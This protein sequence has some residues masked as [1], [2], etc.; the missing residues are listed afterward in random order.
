MTLLIQNGTLVT[1]TKT[2]QSDILI[3]NGKIIQISEKINPPTSKTE[4]IDATNKLILPG[5]I[6]GHTH[7]AMPFGGTI[8][9]DDYYTGTLAAACGGTTTVFDFALQDSGETL[10]ETLKRRDE[11]AKTDVCV[12]YSFH[13]AIKDLSTDEIMKS[14]KDVIEQGITSFKVFMVYDFFVNDKM[15]YIILKKIKEEGGLLGVHAE[16]KGVID[17]LIEQFKEEGKTSAWYHYL[18]RPEFVEEE[19]INR[20]VSFAKSLHAPLYIVHLACKGG[21]EIIQKARDEGYPIFSETCIQ[22][23]HFTNEVFKRENAIEFV[24]SPPMKGEE[25]KQALWNGIKNGTIQTIATDHCPFKKSE[26]LWGENDFIKIP[27][28]CSGVENMYPFMLSHANSGDISFNK[29]VELCCTNPAKLFGIY[30]QKGDLIVGGD[31]DIVLYD[32]E[33]VMTISVDNMHSNVDHTIWEGLEMKGYPVRTYCRG[34]LVYCDGEF[35]GKRGFGQRVFCNKLH[36]DSNE[37]K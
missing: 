17:A 16:N 27:N 26:K 4:I 30:P 34:Q 20:A 7:L 23:L 22:Y 15:F 33:K 21:V 19:A 6:D 28:G 35:V 14:F 9:S 2:Y 12:D 11:L 10:T 32:R 31:A 3:S 37:L 29:V 18:S 1:S 8:S 36:F 25:S 24:C 5:A 13:I